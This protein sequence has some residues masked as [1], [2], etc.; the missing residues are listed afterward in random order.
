MRVDSALNPSNC[1]VRLDAVIMIAA[2]RLVAVARGGC[3]LLAAAASAQVII[4][5]NVV[6]GSGYSQARGIGSNGVVVGSSNLGV[7]TRNV[8]AV[9]TNGVLAT[10][11]GLPNAP[12][13]G[14]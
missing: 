8:A 2:R 1:L 11:P 10:L 9:W 3:I 14:F 6:P 7:N 12:A 4:L 13:G 5:P